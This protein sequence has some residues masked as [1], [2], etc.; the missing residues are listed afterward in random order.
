MMT[1]L[2][3]NYQVVVYPQSGISLTTYL[4][5]V[6][7]DLGSI[8]LYRIYN[9]KEMLNYNILYLH[10][11]CISTLCAYELLLLIES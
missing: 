2:H 6:L 8:L 10:G 1:T 9:I 4:E 3:T 11:L 7:V 5:L